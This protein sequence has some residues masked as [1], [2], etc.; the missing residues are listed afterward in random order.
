VGKEG[1]VGEQVGD[2]PW[3][4]LG[5]WVTREMALRCTA[6]PVVVDADDMSLPS[7]RIWPLDGS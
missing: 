6:K 3:R 5:S 4:R 7:N 2:L 1:K